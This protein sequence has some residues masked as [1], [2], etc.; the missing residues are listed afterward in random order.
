[1]GI[2]DMSSRMN[3]IYR[4]IVDGKFCVLRFDQANVSANFFNLE[5]LAELD[6]HLRDIAADRSIQGVVFISAKERVF[7]AGADLRG[8]EKMDQ[9]GLQHFLER[10]QE[11]FSRVPALGMPTR[12]AI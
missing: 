6:G 5:T 9:P 3:N 11:V 8:L 10:G 12:G 1:M 2:F 4:E 7:H